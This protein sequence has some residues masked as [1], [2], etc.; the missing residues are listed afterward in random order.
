MIGFHATYAGGELRADGQ[1][2]LDARWFRF[3][4]L[5]SIPPKISIARALIDDWVGRAKK[6]AT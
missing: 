3:D 4:A 5:P 6:R 2:I 1:E